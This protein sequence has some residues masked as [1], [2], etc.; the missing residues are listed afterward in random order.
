MS[1]LAFT[2]APLGC[3]KKDGA[4]EEQNEPAVES[5]ESED[6]P[7]EEQRDK[8]TKNPQAKKDDP[9]SSKSGVSTG[10]QGVAVPDGDKNAEQ[11][12][13]DQTAVAASSET[14]K[15]APVPSNP[16]LAV[17]EPAKTALEPA[18]TPGSGLNNVEGEVDKGRQTVPGAPAL[19]NLPDLRLLLTSVDIAQVAG[20]KVEFRRTS[21]P[22]NPPTEDRDSLYFEP[23]K[24]TEFGFGIQIYRE[25][26][27]GRTRDRFSSMLASYPEAQ[28]INPIAGKTFFSYWQDLLHVGF[29]QPG[30]NMVVLLSCGRK[31]CESDALYEL[32]KKV[33]SRIN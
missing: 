7:Q 16:D 27:A 13:G 21:L 31:Y 9:K 28:E 14:A 12:T 25:R 29:V 6:E 32:A 11:P 5:A 4:S 17:G 10:D 22:G 15:P 2:M 33:G 23:V 30:K 24:G 19:P 8:P 20:E 3:G 26:N 18:K 1:I